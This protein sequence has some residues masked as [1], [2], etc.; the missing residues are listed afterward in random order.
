MYNQNLK[1]AM[2][3][4]LGVFQKLMIYMVAYSEALFHLNVKKQ[5]PCIFANINIAGII[6]IRVSNPRFPDM[7]NAMDTLC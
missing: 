7:G 2:L 6:S 4:P 5:N 3:A 1:G